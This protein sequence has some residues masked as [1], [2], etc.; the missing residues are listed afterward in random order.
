MNT[1]RECVV[2]V[3]GAGTM[4]CGIAQVAAAAGHPVLLY[5]AAAG[6]AER[7][8]SVVDSSISDGFL[9]GARLTK[10]ALRVRRPATTTFDITPQALLFD[11]ADKHTR[12]TAFLERRA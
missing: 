6:A 4:G 3:V 1:L 12:M 2:G 11:S 9:A 8:V 10:L 7:A 5:D